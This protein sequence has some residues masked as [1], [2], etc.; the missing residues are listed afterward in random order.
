MSQTGLPDGLKNTIGQYRR[1]PRARED[2]LRQNQQISAN[3][4]LSQW[5]GY[6]TGAHR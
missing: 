1:S 4:T 2:K 6:S 3:A 5:G